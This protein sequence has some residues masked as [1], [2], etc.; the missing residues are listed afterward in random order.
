M[1]LGLKGHSVMIASGDDGVE[2][3]FGCIAGTVFSPGW[4]AT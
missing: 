1:K 4:P 2:G 3:T